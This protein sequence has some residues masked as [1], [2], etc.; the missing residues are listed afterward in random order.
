MSRKRKAAVLGVICF[1]SLSVVT[2][3]CRFA[4]QVQMVTNPDTTYVL[5]RMIVAAAIE[6]EVAVVAVNL[7]ALKSLLSWSMGGSS[8]DYSSSEEHKLPDYKSNSDKGLK[9]SGLS[10]TLRESGSC[11]ILGATLTGSEENLL[12]QH[13]TGPADVRVT[14]NID[15]TSVPYCD[16]TSE[17]P[18]DIGFP[19]SQNA[20]CDVEK[21]R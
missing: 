6:I 2:A 10:T 14:T 9:G 15:I 20:K 7:P 12:R 11:G 21:A 16:G 13:R 5:G 4:L 1:G 17:H 19:A 8:Q 18:M 3:L